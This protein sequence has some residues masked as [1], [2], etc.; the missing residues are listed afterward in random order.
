MRPLFTKPTAMTVVT[1]LDW[2][3]LVT[4]V[5]TPVASSRLL[6]TELI[7]LRSRSP[8]TACNPCDMFLMPSRNMPNPP[9]APNSISRT[10]FE[11]IACL[12]A[13]SVNEVS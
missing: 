5:P 7:S 13:L 10:R 2:M 11:F 3:M 1:E 9:R 4:S 8:A 6:V 12:A